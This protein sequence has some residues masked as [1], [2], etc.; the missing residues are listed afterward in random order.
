MPFSTRPPYIYPGG[1]MMM[2]AP[3]EQQNSMMFGFFIKGDIQKLQR[4]CYQ[5]LNAVAQGRFRF[6]PLT[7]YVMLTFTK[8]NKDYSMHP[9]DRAK[10]WGQE[11]DTSIWVPVGQYKIENNQ[12][13]LLKIHWIMPYI[14]VDHPMTIIN[15]REIFGYPKYL[16]R[17]EM[18]MSSDNADHFSLDVNAFKTFS[19]NSEATWGR[20]LEVN[21]ITNNSPAQIAHQWNTWADFA[22]AVFAGICKLD[23]F[24]LTDTDIDKQ[25]VQGLLSPQLPQLFLK[26][27]PDGTGERAVY[28][29][30]T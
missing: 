26:Q 11:I 28:Q 14:W 17:F 18:P 9:A 21:R 8:I 1:S 7:N 5:Q 2:H 19:P 4:V 10:G 6:E 23:D 3:F 24:I 30:L 12:K 29:A 22:T 25:I 15:G 27:F 20:V 13:T 16:G